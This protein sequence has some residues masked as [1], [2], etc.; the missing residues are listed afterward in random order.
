MPGF[1]VLHHLRSL[2]KLM[3]TE[4]VMLSNHLIFCHPLLLLLSIFPSIR[5][6]SNESALHISPSN[7][8][9]ELISFR[10]DWLDLLTVQGTLTSLQHHNSKASNLRIQTS[11]WSSSHQRTSAQGTATGAL[12]C[13]REDLPHVRGQG[14][15][16]GGP[17]ARRAAAK[18]SYPTS[19]VRG[20]SPEFQTATAQEWL[21]RATQVRGQGWWPRGATQCPKPGA[22]SGRSYPTPPCLRSGAVAGRTNPTSKEW[23]LCRCRRA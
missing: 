10:I 18:R 21:R 6:F 23:W 4:S 22:V 2:F 14:Q 17:H 7:E 16:P 3:S 20:C 11:L 15:K 13:G 9:S 1:P 19:E 12:R 5:V 8:Y